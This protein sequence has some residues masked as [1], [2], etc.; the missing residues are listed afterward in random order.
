MDDG[1]NLIF[2]EAVIVLS[3][4]EQSMGNDPKKALELFSK[5]AKAFDEA[6]DYFR[7]AGNM[8]NVIKCMSLRHYCY[9]RALLV[10]YFSKYAPQERTLIKSWVSGI[11]EK[12]N[13]SHHTVRAEIVGK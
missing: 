5:A 13:Y 9:S 11:S 2:K 3:E 10:L 8:K 4:A 6:S 1:K 7:E 12:R